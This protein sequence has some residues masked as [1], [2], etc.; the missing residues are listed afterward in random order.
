MSRTLCNTRT[1][2]TNVILTQY[3]YFL[4]ST[5][6]LP[7]QATLTHQGWHYSELHAPATTA[8]YHVQTR[9]MGNQSFH[10]LVM[11]SQQIPVKDMLGRPNRRA[12]QLAQLLNYPQRVNKL[13]RATRSC[14]QWSGG[15]H[16][17]YVTQ[18]LYPTPRCTETWQPSASLYSSSLSSSPKETLTSWGHFGLVGGW[19]DNSH[20]NL[21]S[22][23]SF[24]PT[25]DL[26]Y[27]PW[28][29]CP[30]SSLSPFPFSCVPAAP[31]LVPYYCLGF[32]CFYFWY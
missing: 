8:C 6:C 27:P 26:T 25:T 32:I 19:W 15:S 31:H 1:H 21:H 5:Q 13:A 17:A 22:S 9:I 11:V 18:V 14:R 10:Q 24:C 16:Q 29:F 4:E 2:Q 30:A 7:C 28:W 12:G 23:S 20:P 3:P